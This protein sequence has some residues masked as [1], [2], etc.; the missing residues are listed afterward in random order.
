MQAPNQISWLKLSKNSASKKR[1]SWNR[2]SWATS[3][4]IRLRRSTQRRH[5]LTKI[6]TQVEHCIWIANQLSCTM[7][8][9]T[10]LA[11]KSIA[12]NAISGKYP[13]R[14]RWL[15]TQWHSSMAR[16]TFWPR[17]EVNQT[18]RCSQVWHLPTIRPWTCHTS[19]RARYA[20]TT[21]TKDKDKDK[22]Q[23]EASWH[24]LKVKIKT[25]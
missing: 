1:T 12:V 16:R 2:Q 23:E 17:R 3:P 18:K 24:T 20:Q 25:K 10:D 8:A 21:R 7:M 11:R 19:H 22:E 14:A 5:L 15:C 9:V 4:T 13:T 6:T